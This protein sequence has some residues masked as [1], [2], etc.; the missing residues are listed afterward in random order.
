MNAKTQSR[1]LSKIIGE[2]SVIASV[3]ASTPG[4]TRLDKQASLKS[5]RDHGAKEGIGKT[6]VTRMPGAEAPMEEIKALDRQGRKLLMSYT[7]QWGLDRRLLPNVYIGEFSGKFEDLRRVRD[8]L[9]K[10]FLMDAKL[11]LAQAKT[12]LGSYAVQ[13]PTMDELINAFDFGFDLSPVPDVDAYS[14]ADKALEQAMKA[15]FDDDVAA[16]FHNAQRDLMLRL[17]EPLEN[18]I[19]RMKEYDRREERKANGEDVGKTGTFK[20]S[21]V[22]NITEMAKLVRHFNFTNEPKI[23]AI[24]EKLE[25]FNQIDHDTLTAYPHV[26]KAVAERAAE[27]RKGLGAWVS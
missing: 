3:H 11:Y 2:M 23:E 17:A 9:V 1:P 26:R 16:S 27:I 12:N 10:Q 7:T 21:V 8:V 15:R 14:T 25:V 20:K 6:S 19:D 18:L 24:A 4:M 5:D 22:T 13:P